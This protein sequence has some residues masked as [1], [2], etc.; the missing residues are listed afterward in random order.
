MMTNLEHWRAAVSSPK[1]AGMPQGQAAELT[2]RLAFAAVLQDGG[3]VRD[4]AR[5]AR[6]ER[7]ALVGDAGW[8][9]TAAATGRLSWT[10]RP[11]DD[12]LAAVN[13]ALC[14]S[15]GWRSLPLPE[16]AR[17]HSTGARFMIENWRAAEPGPQAE[18]L[19][20]AALLSGGGN[21][22]LKMLPPGEGAMLALD[23]QRHLTDV[24]AGKVALGD[25]ST[26]IG[27]AY[28]IDVSYVS[29]QVEAF[30]QERG[31]AKGVDIAAAAERKPAAAPPTAEAAPKPSAAGIDLAAAS[32]EKA[33]G[34]SA[35]AFH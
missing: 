35:P 18:R 28:R 9:A 7:L 16:D 34:S 32:R 13:A 15:L 26:G 10:D 30:Y 1:P 12:N 8:Y 21:E 20:Y 4:D 5:L 22:L 24:Q 33:P 31:A 3:L 29:S 2:R 6:E 25:T 14:S 17:E 19:A 23:A 11:H 27:Y